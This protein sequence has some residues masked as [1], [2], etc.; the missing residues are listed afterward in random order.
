[1]NA[2]L[3]SPAARELDQVTAA[4]SDLSASMDRHAD[5]PEVLDACAL[6]VAR[7]REQLDLRTSVGGAI[8]GGIAET[9]V[10]TVAPD[11]VNTRHMVISS[12]ALRG[13]AAEIVAINLRFELELYEYLA[14]MP[15]VRQE[16]H[17]KRAAVIRERLS[18]KTEP[19]ETV[20]FG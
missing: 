1:M 14:N 16:S 7:S 19:L 15:S 17:A 12:K 11:T 20:P 5:D 3:G 4:R 6:I 2:I 9:I 18:A 13:R 10:D 8:H